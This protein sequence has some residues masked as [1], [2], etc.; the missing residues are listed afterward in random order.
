MCPTIKEKTIGE[1]NNVHADIYKKNI[2]QWNYLF[3]LDIVHHQQC[4]LQFN[5]SK[6]VMAA[7]FAFTKCEYIYISNFKKAITVALFSFL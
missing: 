4:S 3:G 6:T 1:N 7:V 5:K 2:W